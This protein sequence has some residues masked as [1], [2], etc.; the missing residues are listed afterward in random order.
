MANN[1]TWSLPINISDDKNIDLPSNT[2]KT[3]LAVYVSIPAGF[4]TKLALCLMLGAISLTGDRIQSSRFV[5]NLNLYLR[6]LALSDLLGCAVLP[7]VC[8][9][10]AFDIFQSGWTCKIVRYLSIAFMC[11]TI[12]ILV[13]I[14]LEKYLSTRRIPLTFMPRIPCG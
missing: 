13:V 7:L 1:Y 11:V 4:K 5:K 10:V 6:N 14:S 12:N 3:R 2:D 9:E 8:I